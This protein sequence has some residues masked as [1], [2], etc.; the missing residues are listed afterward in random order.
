MCMGLASNHSN[1]SSTWNEILS[2]GTVWQSVLSQLDRD[3]TADEILG[4]NSRGASWLFVGC[5]TSFYLAQAAASS[6]ISTT[7]ES[8]R[9]VPASEILLYTQLL[10]MNGAQSR[11]VVISRSGRTSEAIRAAQVLK[12]DLHIRTIGITCA[13][14]SELAAH[15]DSMI[16]VHAA[17]EKSTVM[18]RSFTSMLISLQYLAAK[19]A[20]DAKFLADLTTVAHSFP[21]RIASLVKQM[22]SFAARHSFDDYVFLGQGPFYALA[23]E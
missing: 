1:Q 19:Q 14:N 6:W 7:G 11:A 18:T 5:G 15:C 10:K 4:N 17:D 16:V 20:G 13:E 3:S 2:Q 8:A 23:Q 9:A 22:K 12:R 21:T